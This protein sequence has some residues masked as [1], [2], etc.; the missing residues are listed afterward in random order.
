MAADPRR[1]RRI[2]ADAGC[3]ARLPIRSR[4][5]RRRDWSLSY[6]DLEAGWIAKEDKFS[7][8][9]EVEAISVARS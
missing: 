7:G 3:E 8:G 9:L 6:L 1:N 4:V 2:D 5:G